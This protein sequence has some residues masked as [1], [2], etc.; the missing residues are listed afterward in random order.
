VCFPQKFKKL[1]PQNGCYL[2][3][4]KESKKLRARTVERMNEERLPKDELHLST[5]G[6]RIYILWRIDPLVGKDLKTN[7]ETTAVAM[8]RRGKHAFET[9]FST[10]PVQRGYKENNWGWPS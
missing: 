10:R 9:V 7:N 3:S 4:E 6:K 8:Q 5:N 2:I 1:E